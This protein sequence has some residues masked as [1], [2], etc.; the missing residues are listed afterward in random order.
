MSV[1]A[2]FDLDSGI[3]SNAAIRQVRIWDRALTDQ[4]LKEVATLK[5][6]GEEEG[7]VACWPLDDGGGKKARDL[8]PHGLDLQI[9]FSALKSGSDPRWVHTCG[10]GRAAGA[11]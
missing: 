1:G 4:E 5:V 8:G 7:L 11:H 3:Q 2:V 10:H 6:T 9:G